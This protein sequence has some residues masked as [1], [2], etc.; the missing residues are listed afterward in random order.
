MASVN[1]A[2][3][4]RPFKLTYLL[5][6]AE[7]A[8]KQHPG[9]PSHPVA[10][11]GCVGATRQRQAS[12]MFLQVYLA[13][14][15]LQSVV[16]FQGKLHFTPLLGHICFIWSNEHPELPKSCS[17][18][19]RTR[20]KWRKGSVSFVLKIR[21]LKIWPKSL[22]LVFPTRELSEALSFLKSKYLCEPSIPC[23][24]LARLLSTILNHEDKHKRRGRFPFPQISKEP[25][26]SSHVDS[27]T[28]WFQPANTIFPQLEAT[29]TKITNV[30]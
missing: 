18:L 11:G 21:N 22:P 28:K 7:T 29:Q 24:P 10:S 20:R 16:F 27:S 13:Q 3:D 1:T 15:G 12:G 9:E 19:W 30:N 2:A 4:K 14:K 23:G 6:Q 17:C 5:L 26:S 8:L 25:R